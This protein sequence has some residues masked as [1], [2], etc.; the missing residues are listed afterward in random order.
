MCRAR[1]MTGRKDRVVISTY[2]VAKLFNARKSGL[3]D[4]LSF[5]NLGTIERYN[6]I[7]GS[8]GLGKKEAIE[9]LRGAIISHSRDRNLPYELC[10][11]QQLIYKV[12]FETHY[13]KI[14]I[15][16]DRILYLNQETMDA[17]NNTYRSRHKIPT[18]ANVMKLARE[19]GSETV[20]IASL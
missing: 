18:W 13:V 10:L 12:C 5:I 19:Y 7:R 8:F 4:T 11:R 6:K 3:V 1:K 20:T 16:N 17:I 9:I 2:L 14:P 15:I